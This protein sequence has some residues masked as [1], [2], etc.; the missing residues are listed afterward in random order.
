MFCSVDHYVGVRGASGFCL[1]LCYIYIV[2]W[3]ACQVD[4]VCAHSGHLSVLP[5]FLSLPVSYSD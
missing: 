5:H 2:A 1:S 4:K 3:W